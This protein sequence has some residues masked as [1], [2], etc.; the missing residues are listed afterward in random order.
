MFPNPRDFAKRFVESMETPPNAAQGFQGGLEES[1]VNSQ[2]ISAS[3]PPVQG[4]KYRK[5]TPDEAD[6]HIADT[7][8]LTTIAS[9]T[10]G[11][12]V[13][14]VPGAI[15]GFTSKAVGEHFGPKIE[16]HIRN[17]EWVP[18][19]DNWTEN[20]FWNEYGGR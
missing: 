7:K 13:G 4:P 3:S 11:L 5:P 6:Q 2:N 17:S 15:A 12:A 16:K 18:V 14:G 8:A 20:D 9:G 19:Y 10:L 1:L